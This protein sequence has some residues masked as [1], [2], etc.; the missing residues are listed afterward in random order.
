MLHGVSD[1]TRLPLTDSIAKCF[2]LSCTKCWPSMNCVL[3]LNAL[4]N[5]S[6]GIYIVSTASYWKLELLAAL[7]AVFSSTKTITLVACSVCRSHFLHARLSA[8]LHGFMVISGVMFVSGVFSLLCILPE[9][10]AMDSDILYMKVAL[11]I[12]YSLCDAIHAVCSLFFYVATTRGLDPPPRTFIREIEGEHDPDALTTLKNVTLNTF[13]FNEKISTDDHPVH[14]T[15]LKVCCIC[16]CE[17]LPNEVVTELTCHHHYHLPCVSTWV[18]SQ[19]GQS[20]LCPLR[21][22]LRKEVATTS[23][24]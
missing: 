2:E 8:L 4:L 10:Q 18:R 14:A 20:P 3:L 23:D 15:D 24:G 11:F 19:R 1:A 5:A 21:C 17:F 9:L 13:V 6:L 12:F 16:L 7:Q 22:D